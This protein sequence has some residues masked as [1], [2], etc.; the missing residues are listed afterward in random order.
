MVVYTPFRLHLSWTDEYLKNVFLT[1]SLKG[2]FSLVCKI[3]TQNPVI[4]RIAYIDIKV[5]YYVVLGK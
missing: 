5:T 4:P 2:T 3:K 1:T